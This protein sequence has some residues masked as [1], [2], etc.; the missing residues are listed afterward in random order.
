MKMTTQA[1]VR[2]VGTADDAA[3]LRTGCDVD[4]PV[5]ACLQHPEF[6]REPSASPVPPSLN[7]YH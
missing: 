3:D 5:W 2:S 7:R 6:D 1:N 4:E